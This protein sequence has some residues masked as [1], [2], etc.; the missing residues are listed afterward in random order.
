[1]IPGATGT[2]TQVTTGARRTETTG[3]NGELRF[4]ALVASTYKLEVTKHGFKT[5]T[6]DGIELQ[7]SEIRDLGKLVLQI[8]SLTESVEVTA[9]ATPVQTASSE[10]ADSVTSAQLDNVTMKGRDPLRR[11]S[12]SS[13]RYGHQPQP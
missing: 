12:S 9:E 8:G 13:G 1:V 7:T 4:E 11:T 2:L 6:I 3:Q 5:L 10:R